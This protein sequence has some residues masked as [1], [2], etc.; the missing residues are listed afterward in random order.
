MKGARMGDTS[1]HLEPFVLPA[2]PADVDAPAEEVAARHREVRLHSSEH[3][4]LHLELWREISERGWPGLIFSV[5]S[6][7][8]ER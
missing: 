2:A 7:T 4:E 5:A 8:L 6:F 1:A 3:S